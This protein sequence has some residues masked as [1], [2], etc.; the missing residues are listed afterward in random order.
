MIGNWVRTYRQQRTDPE[1]YSARSRERGDREGVG[2]RMKRDFGMLVSSKKNV[3]GLWRSR[4]E[5]LMN[6]EEAIFK[7]IG[8]ESCSKKEKDV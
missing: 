7:S 2:L 8:K 5:R 6:G 4:F 1:N 3:K